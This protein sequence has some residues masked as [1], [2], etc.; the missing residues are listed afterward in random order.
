ME[1][2]IAI[3]IFLL[4]LGS[5]V[6]TFVAIIQILSN[7]FKESKGLWIIIS[8]IAFIGPILW[9]TKG[10]KHIVKRTA[11]EKK[12]IKAG[13][14]SK[15]HYLEL[16]ESLSPLLKWIVI[17]GISLIVYGYLSIIASIYFFWESK[18]IGWILVL[19]GLTAFLWKDIQTRKAK[20]IPKVWSSI[21]FGLLCF[22]IF[23]KGL[24]SVLIPT[25]D[26]YN[27]AKT[28]LANMES[29]TNETGEIE[30]YGF[31]TNG[32]LSTSTDATGTY[33]SAA[34]EIIIKG[35]KKYIERTIFL[36]STPQKPWT[37]IKIVE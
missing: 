23:V 18:S 35:K 34:L 20:G 28:Q 19:I 12:E 36:E 31:R 27:T 32:S 15:T 8:M 25:S 11:E 2:F 14:S 4:V 17:A 33:R 16:L 9:L 26:A 24:M 1:A 21:G 37:I 30:G 29:I 7:D 3:L 6:T 22:I 5:L 13:F 10:R